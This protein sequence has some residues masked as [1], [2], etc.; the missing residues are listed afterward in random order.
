M[1]TSSPSLLCPWIAAFWLIALALTLGL[2][3]PASAHPVLQNPIWIEVA[4]D[5][6]EVKLFVSM[7]ELNV[8]QGLPIA[9]D[10]AVDMAE[11]EEAAPRHTPYLLDHL[12][13]KADG[14]LLQGRVEQVTPPKHVGKGVE[15]PDRAHF[16]YQIKYPMAVPPARI[17]FSQTMVKEF[18]SAPGVPWD[19][20]Y[21]YRFRPLGAPHWLQFGALPRDTEV[22]YETPFPR[23]AGAETPPAAATTPSSPRGP[24]T[25]LALL[26]LALGLGLASRTLMARTIGV[27]LTAFLAGWGIGYGLGLPMPSFLAAA[28][29][30]IGILLVSVDNIHREAATPLTRRWLMAG[31]FPAAAGW[32]AWGATSAVPA[33]GPRL[34][35]LSLL[36]LLGATVVGSVL[37]M[38]R[39]TAP[40]QEGSTGK[41]GLVQAISL[42]VCLGGLVILCDGLRIRP[43][44]Y[45]LARLGG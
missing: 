19:L 35:G 1:K 4:P 5:R 11:A 34:A 2:A 41:S 43:W 3:G 25:G 29:A 44:T 7:R 36:A 24:L 32:A 45:W 42:G 8:V 39:F 27:V 21:A 22:F 40:A 17:T 23:T 13:F 6:L 18:P 16:I 38:R 9:A 28:L 15:G 33:L 10:G 12:F 30:G 31:I 26:G 37:A 14:Q 20:S